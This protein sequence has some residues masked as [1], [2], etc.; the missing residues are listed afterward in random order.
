MAYGTDKATATTPID[1]I[2]GS[3]AGWERIYLRGGAIA[4]IFVPIQICEI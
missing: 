1:H 2:E 4:I 3:H